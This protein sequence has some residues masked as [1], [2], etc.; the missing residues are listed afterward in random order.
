[1]SVTNQDARQL[2]PKLD[3]PGAGLPLPE[4]FVARAMFRVQRFLKSR[5]DWTELFKTEQAAILQLAQSVKEEDGATQI[6]VRRIRGM[7]DSSRFWSVYMVLDHLN[8]VNGAFTGAILSLAKG[9]VPE[10]K[11]NTADVKPDPD[12]TVETVTKFQK[13]CDAFLEKTVKVAN[14]ST[15]ARYRHPWFGPLDA[16]GWHA[17]AAFHMRLH[18]KQI[19]QIVNQLP[20]TD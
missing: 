4:L 7:E 5:E 9:R 6:L 19:E 20:A 15:K 12:C 17:L 1:M 14:L 10:R 2:Q 13:T 18:R 11:A 16:A 3:A 8:I